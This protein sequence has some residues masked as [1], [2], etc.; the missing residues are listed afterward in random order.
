MQEP[1]GQFLPLL[2]ACALQDQPR[3]LLLTHL[4]SVKRLHLPFARHF[5]VWG[6]FA[7]N[8]RQPLRHVPTHVLPTGVGLQLKEVPSGAEG[9]G[10]V[11]AASRHTHTH[12]LHT[13][14]VANIDAGE[15]LDSAVHSQA[16]PVKTHCLLP[17]SRPPGGVAE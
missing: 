6:R 13:V 4:S 9:L 11:Q 12:K 10:T 7:D 2:L 16:L 17:P 8:C 1:T 3:P 15:L 5:T 14:R